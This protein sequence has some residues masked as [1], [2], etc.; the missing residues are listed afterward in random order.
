MFIFR[1][2]ALSLVAILMVANFYSSSCLDFRLLIFRIIFLGW[3]LVAIL[4]VP[5][6]LVLPPVFMGFRLLIFRVIL[7]WTLVAILVVANPLI[8]PLVTFSC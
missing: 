7:P 4:L 1:V 2:L 8:L 3:T 6:L 5:N